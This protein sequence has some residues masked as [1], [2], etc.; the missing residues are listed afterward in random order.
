MCG[1]QYIETDVRI[2]KDGHILV[3]HDED[4]DRLCGDPRKVCDVNL[5]DLPKFKSQ[6]PMH[7]SK[8]NKNAEFQTYARKVGDQD[9]FSTLEEVF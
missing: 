4:F 5:A 6:M 2:T 8:L 9:C 3:C 1:A 7:F